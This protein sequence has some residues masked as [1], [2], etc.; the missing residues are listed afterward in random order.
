MPLGISTPDQPNISSTRWR[1]VADHKNKVYYFDSATSPTVFWVPLA[2]LNLEE[3]APVKK[4]TLVGN[5][6]YSGSAASKFESAEP[7]VFL[8]ATVK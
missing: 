1:T 5:K 8:P 7:F 6:T 2:E 3:G 4:L